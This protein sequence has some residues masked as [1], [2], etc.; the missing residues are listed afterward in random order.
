MMAGEEVELS[1][2][3]EISLVDGSHGTAPAKKKKSNGE[4]QQVR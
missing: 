1:E 4:L 2:L 3:D